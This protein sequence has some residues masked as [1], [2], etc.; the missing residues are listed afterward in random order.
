[1]PARE[2][3]HA[4][5]LLP[6]RATFQRFA[7]RFLQRGELERL[8]QNRKPRLRRLHHIAVAAGE[9]DWDVRVV[10]ADLLRQY[11]AVHAAGHH[12]VAEDKVDLV[13]ALQ[14]IEGLGGVLRPRGLVTQLLDE[15][16][17]D[18]S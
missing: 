2:L 5:A 7:N 9:D 13:A 10:V 18:F 6:R 8:A 15:R 1:A 4:I 17:G 11:D 3:Q 12:D 16:S 14:P